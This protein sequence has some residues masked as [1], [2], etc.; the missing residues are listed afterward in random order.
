MRPGETGVRVVGKVP[1]ELRDELAPYFDAATVDV[2]GSWLC[3]R[4][5]EASAAAPLSALAKLAPGAWV[6]ECA[7]EHV[8]PLARA[9]AWTPRSRQRVRAT[10]S[11]ARAFV[12]LGLRGIEQ[13][14]CAGFPGVVVTL[15]QR[16]AELP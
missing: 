15:G 3:V 11:R 12:E 16:P 10:E 7:Y 1:P 9:V 13:W 2:P 4:R 6:V 8:H 5:L 14:A